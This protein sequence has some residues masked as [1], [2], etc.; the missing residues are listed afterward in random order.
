MIVDIVISIDVEVAVDVVNAKH[1]TALNSLVIFTKAPL[2][3]TFITNDYQLLQLN[4][5]A[6]LAKKRKLLP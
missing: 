3:Q 2:L 6:R 1:R 5:I 4:F